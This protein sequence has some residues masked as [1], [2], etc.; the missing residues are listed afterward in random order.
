MEAIVSQEPMTNRTQ[1]GGP[2]NPPLA[3]KRPIFR[4]E[5]RQH[6]LQ[7]KE[8]VDLPRLVSSRVFVFLWILALL[9][10]VAGAIIAFWPLMGHAW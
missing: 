5:A 4:P 2:P 10:T 3:P 9:L 6:Y 7:N 1:N 8:K